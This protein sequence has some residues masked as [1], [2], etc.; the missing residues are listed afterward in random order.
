MNCCGS[1]NTISEYRISQLKFA[2]DMELLESSKNYF[3]YALNRFTA[4][5]NERQKWFH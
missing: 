4:L 5:T 1:D 2:D 3:Q